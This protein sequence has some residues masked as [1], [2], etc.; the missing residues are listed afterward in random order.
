MRGGYYSFES[1]FIRNLPIRTINFSEPADKGAHD[2]RVQLVDSM[3]TLE[4]NLP[5]R[6]RMRK[7]TS[8]SGRSMRLTP[9]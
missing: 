6:H 3:L 5:P 8:S 4:G 9:R 1:R 7:K 2:R